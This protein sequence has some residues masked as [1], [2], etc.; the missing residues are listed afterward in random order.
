MLNATFSNFLRFHEKFVDFVSYINYKC[1][2]PIRL[3]TIP[4]RGKGIALILLQLCEHS[5]SK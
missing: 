4:V 5:A 2:S 3:L 1:F